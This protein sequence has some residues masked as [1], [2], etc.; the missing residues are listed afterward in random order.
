[1]DKGLKITLWMYQWSSFFDKRRNRWLIFDICREIECLL[2]NRVE[3]PQNYRLYRVIK[4]YTFYK[5]YTFCRNWLFF[6][7]KFAFVNHECLHQ[8]HLVIF[9]LKYFYSPWK[10]NS[11]NLPPTSS[12]LSIMW[13]FFNGRFFL[14]FSY[15]AGRH[16]PGVFFWKI[17]L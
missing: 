7:Y 9:E 17:Y 8:S 1:M 14:L 6:Y 12:I 16:L 4:T 11:T 10:V 15:C 13:N 5:T 2:C 3:L